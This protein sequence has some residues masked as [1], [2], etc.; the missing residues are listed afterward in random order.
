MM[1]EAE[2]RADEIK[3]E[4]REDREVLRRQVDQLQ[5]RRDKTVAG[6]RAFLMSEMELLLR[7]DGEDPEALRQSLPDEL[8]QH[9]SGSETRSEDAAEEAPA[10]AAEPE[11]TPAPPRADPEEEAEGRPATQAPR[12]G[13]AGEGPP[14][15]L[16][17]TEDFDETETFRDTNNARQTAAPEEAPPEETPPEETPPAAASVVSLSKAATQ[18]SVFHG[19]PSTICPTDSSSYAKPSSSNDRTTE[20]TIPRIV[21]EAPPPR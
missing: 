21:S 17:V 3:R 6:L 1:Q 19:T 14:P 7:F 5:E 13:N 2:T 12:Q 10:P 16:P 20:T 15:D 4:A 11:E 8:A 9:V 18:S